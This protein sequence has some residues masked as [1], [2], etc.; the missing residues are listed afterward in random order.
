[1]GFVGRTERL[2]DRQERLCRPT[3]ALGSINCRPRLQAYATARFYSLASSR[4]LR[5]SELVGLDVTDALTDD[6][7]GHAQI[8]PEGLFIKLAR[9]KTDQAGAGQESV[10]RRRDDLCPVQA[11]QAWLGSSS[12]TSGAVFRTINKAGALGSRLTAQSAR[13][14]VQRHLGADDTAHG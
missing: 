11:L 12:I 5:R 6:A 10:P 13:L 1:M 8:V 9:S 7:T 2:S 14:I 4:A 3:F